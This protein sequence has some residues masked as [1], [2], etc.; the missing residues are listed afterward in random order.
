MNKIEEYDE[1]LKEDINKLERHVSQEEELAKD[2][3]RSYDTSEKVI[4]EVTKKARLEGNRIS[5]F[6]DASSVNHLAE[7]LLD[8]MDIYKAFPFRVGTGY[9]MGTK[10]QLILEDSWA[11]FDTRPL[12][13]YERIEYVKYWQDTFRLNY[14]SK[15]ASVYNYYPTV[16]LMKFISKI[17]IQYKVEDVSSIDEY[18]DENMKQAWD[19]L[20][21]NF[22]TKK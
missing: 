17:L 3:M 19:S 12:T 1:Q 22:K 20:E 5:F 14:V 6:S 8:I 2:Y 16:E 9:F 15:E 11:F 18:Y 7:T 21:W 13:D 10:L 4:K